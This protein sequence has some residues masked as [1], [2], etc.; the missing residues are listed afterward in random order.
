VDTKTGLLL[1]E[2]EGMAQQ[3]SGSGNILVDLISAAV[4][5][6][7][8]ASTDAAHPVCRLA[9]AN[10]LAAEGRRFLYGPYHPQ[11]GKDE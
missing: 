2:A 3:N 1:W 7:V 10:L 9:N 11:Y 6:A 8:N 4:T 5:Q